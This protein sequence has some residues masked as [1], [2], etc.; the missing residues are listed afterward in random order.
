MFQMLNNIVLV[1]R[2]VLKCSNLPFC[3]HQQNAILPT[4][5]KWSEQS[6][7]YLVISRGISR[8]KP[9]GIPDG[10]Q[11]IILNF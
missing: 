11:T 6:R 5:E 7:E 9:Y 1:K 10:L 4:Q 3:W 8:D 2:C